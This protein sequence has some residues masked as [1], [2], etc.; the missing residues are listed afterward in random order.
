MAS[1]P[2]MATARWVSIAQTLVT[3]GWGPLRSPCNLAL[4][5]GCPGGASSHAWMAHFERCRAPSS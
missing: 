4:G 3:A 5:S 2:C 1:P